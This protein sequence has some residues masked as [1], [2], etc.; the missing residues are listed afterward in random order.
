MSSNIQLWVK[1]QNLELNDKSQEFKHNFE[2]CLNKRYV[3]TTS[4]TSFNFTI[5]EIEVEEGFHKHCLY[6]HCF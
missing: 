2:C 1:L 3:P 6:L 4:L 5:K